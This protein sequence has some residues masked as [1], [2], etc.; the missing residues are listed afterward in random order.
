MNNLYHSVD[1]GLESEQYFPSIG[2]PNKL[3]VWFFRL[4]R[5]RKGPG[6]HGQTTKD[7]SSR[8]GEYAR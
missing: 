4:D 7:S 2:E 3:C 5:K 1:I 6:F 8:C